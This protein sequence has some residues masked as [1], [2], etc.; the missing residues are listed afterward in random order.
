MATFKEIAALAGVSRGTVDR[1]LNHRGDVNPQTEEK[2]MEIVRALDYRPN[3]A[4]IVLAAQKKNLKLGVVLLGVGNP[5]FEDVLQGVREKAEELAGYNCS[6]LIKQTEYSLQQQ[7]DAID[8]LLAEGVGG[9]AISPYNDCAVREKI[10]SLCEQGIPVVTL[11]TDIENASRLAYVG[12]NFYR[13]GEAAGGL[14]RL[15]A[16][17][18][19]RVGIVSGSQNI[20]CHTERIAGFAHIIA[21]YPHIRIVDT[22]NNNDDDQVS[23]ELTKKLLLDHPEIN[24]FYF[25]AGGV[26]GGCQ[27]IE[28]CAR[29]NDITVITND[30]VPTTR[31]YMEKGLI[32]ATIC[33]QPLQQGS[34][35]LAILFACLAAGEMPA[36]ENNY[37]DVEIRIRENL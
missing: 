7:L 18:E 8:A 2:I 30:L 12:S 13:S 10:D 29:T 26:F 15:M 32:A 3:K 22:V 11:N 31:E 16:K 14:M 25:T 19:V 37:V 6:V 33:Q 1:V 36:S 9:L 21:P 20:L 28:T 27:A 4:G 35:P 34:L 5:F 23:F 17:G 24:A